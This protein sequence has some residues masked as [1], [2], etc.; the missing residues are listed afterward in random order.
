MAKLNRT[1]Q[2]V[3]PH[4]RASCSSSLRLSGR[5]AAITGQAAVGADHPVAGHDQ[6]DGI[7]AI[8]GAHRAGGVGW[9][10]RLGDRAIAG[11]GAEGNIQ[12]RRPDTCLSNSGPSGSQFEFEIAALALGI[13]R[14]LALDLGQLA[15]NCFPPRD[16]T[17]AAPAA[18]RLK[19]SSRP[20]SST[21]AANFWNGEFD[22]API[23]FSCRFFQTG[24]QMH[25]GQAAM[26]REARHQPRRLVAH[27][28]VPAACA[29][30]A[31]PSPGRC[32]PPARHR[33]SRRASA[34]SAPSRCRY[35]AAPSASFP[36]RWPS[37]RPGLR[38]PARRRPRPAPHRSDS[39]PWSGN[40]AA[41]S[42][43]RYRY[44]RPRP[45]WDG[46][47]CRRSSRPPVRPISR[48]RLEANLTLICWPMMPQHRASNPVG[49]SGMRRPRRG[50]RKG[51]MAGFELA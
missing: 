37:R 12:Q 39:W 42:A 33:Q 47:A 49:S 22:Q 24:P 6:G 2:T 45:A 51:G 16:R 28:A 21:Q 35:R 50:L 10:M 29:A 27:R 18:R 25:G 14:H 43:P 34:H 32:R 36:P 11:G 46:R 19:R 5:P 9:P 13:F 48:R 8:G 17:L 40:S 30:V 7:G 26:G 23:A 38:Y 4:T 1:D 41:M 31:G 3:V 44:R 20:S 15:A